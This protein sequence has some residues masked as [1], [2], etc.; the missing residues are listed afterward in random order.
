MIIA[1][2]QTMHLEIILSYNFSFGA[3]GSV[4]A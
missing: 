4:V 2:L 3:S 1:K